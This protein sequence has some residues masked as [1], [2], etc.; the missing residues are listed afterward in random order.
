MARKIPV[1]WT[2]S[3]KSARVALDGHDIVAFWDRD[4]KLL[5][6]ALTITTSDETAGTYESDPVADSADATTALS[7]DLDAGS[8]NY[9]QVAPTKFSGLQRYAWFTSDVVEGYA[10]TVTPAAA[11]NKAY[12]VAETG[13]CNLAATNTD[14]GDTYAAEFQLFPDT[15]ADNTGD[16]VLFGADAPFDRLVVNMSA[17]VQVYDEAA[18]LEWEY[19]DGDSWET[20]TITTDGTSATTQDGSIAFGQDGTIIFT[21]PSDWAASTIDSQLAYW[22]R[23]I[24]ATDKSDN[25]TTVGILSDEAA[26]VAALAETAYVVVRDLK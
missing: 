11:Y 20:L 15:D 2:N 17:T 4:D 3:V 14:Y 10:A 22:I 9:V 23:A 5:G 12:N 19:W 13:L 16:Y 7:I 6:S 24:V 25:I 18:V 8:H 26:P 21:R 1:I